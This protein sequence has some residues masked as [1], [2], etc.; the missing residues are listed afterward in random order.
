MRHHLKTDL[1]NYSIQKQVIMIGEIW[2]HQ[3][4][5]WSIG[6]RRSVSALVKALSFALLLISSATCK[7]ILI[8][9][10]KTV[11][12]L[13]CWIHWSLKRIFYMQTF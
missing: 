5:L 8:C 3:R 9:A 10:Q 2:L 1:R 11:V 12:K 4:L 13:M 7:R 6:F